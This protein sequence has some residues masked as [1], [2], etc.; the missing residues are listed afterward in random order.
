M[1]G[2]RFAPFEFLCT[3]GVVEETPVAADGALQRPLP[4]LVESLDDVDVDLVALGQRQHVLDDA[5]LVR[6]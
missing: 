6:P 4:G 2:H 5:G 3:V 1:I